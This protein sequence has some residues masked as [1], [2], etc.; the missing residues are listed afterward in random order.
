MIFAFPAFIGRKFLK[1][2]NSLGRFS[3]FI[4]EILKVFITS[5]CSL[6]ELLIQMEH[7]GVQSLSIV[8]LTSFFTG[9]VFALQCYIGFARI[10]GEQFIGA[11]IVLGMIKEL[12]PI[13]AGL[14][15]AA[16]AG[17]AMA[18][19][20]ATMQITEQIDALKTLH[21]NPI[22]YLII[23]RVLGAT[24]I[25]PFLGIF[26]MLFGVLGGYIVCIYLLALNPE[27]FMNNIISYITLFDIIGGLI[28]SAIFGLIL[29]II[30][31]YKGLYTLGGARGVGQST[32]AT[33][34]SSSITILITNYF[35]SQLLEAL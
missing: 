12:G 22:S 32:T 28:K 19:E 15:V 3:L 7:I 31:C 10:G 11:V 17:S 16:R 14:M 6:K 5:L 34:V 27:D 13:L 26:S 9:M 25:M 21:I 24:L 4:Y 18:A 23:P 1:Y 29:S 33:V 35:L 30:G 20:L 8:I 2:I